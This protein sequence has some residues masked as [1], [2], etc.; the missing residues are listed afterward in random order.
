[1]E[2]DDK[3]LLILA[4]LTAII[5][6]VALIPVLY[7]KAP[8]QANLKPQNELDNSL[9]L[10]QGNTLEAVVPPAIVKK[11][12]LGAFV[13]KENKEI[14]E[15]ILFCESS[16][17]HYLKDGRVIRGKLDEI[18][19]AQY[20]PKTW[21]WFNELRGTNLDIFNKAHQIEMLNWALENNLGKHWVCYRK[22]L[23]K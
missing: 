13:N 9:I 3:R 12:V 22:I 6:G 8:E 10:I 19:I 21:K 11:Q 4:I 2:P 14:I 18:G 16:N 7:P 15:R 23:D 17:R 1:M 5:W 20:R